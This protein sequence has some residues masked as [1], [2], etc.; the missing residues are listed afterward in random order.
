M[1][2][3][4]QQYHK[5]RGPYLR[6]L[7]SLGLRSFPLHSLD[8]CFIFLSTRGEQTETRTL[9]ASVR[10]PLRKD[11]CDFRSSLSGIHCITKHYIVLLTFLQFKALNFRW[12]ET[13][14]LFSEVII[15]CM[16]SLFRTGNPKLSPVDTHR[17]QD[18]SDI[19]RPII[20]QTPISPQ[21]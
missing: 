17:M 2:S 3:S 16:F 13:V 6:S 10:A 14:T 1:Q 19:Y 21:Q 8:S 12:L 4:C 20:S 11:T 18:F 9:W 7:F 15:V 5:V